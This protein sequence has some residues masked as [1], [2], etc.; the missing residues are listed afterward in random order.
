M[1]LEGEAAALAALAEAAERALV[2]S[3]LNATRLPWRPRYRHRHGMH[4]GNAGFEKRA[5]VCCPFVAGALVDASSG[6]PLKDPPLR[7][8]TQRATCRE[9][10]G[11]ASTGGGDLPAAAEA[12]L[13]EMAEAE[14]AAKLAA[15]AG[16]GAAT[17]SSRKAAAAAAA[18]VAVAG[19][20]AHVEALEAL[21]GG[22][23]A[24]AA[25]NETFDYRPR[26]KQFWA[27]L[28]LRLRVWDRDFVKDR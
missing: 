13:A 7:F 5:R 9:A 22:G 11:G 19:G 4:P 14:A 26:P 2:V 23:G 28:A 15:A 18:A 1:G 27:G 20:S 17:A 24:F 8:Q 12:V 21:R 6:E 16:G 3:V 25:W 10:P